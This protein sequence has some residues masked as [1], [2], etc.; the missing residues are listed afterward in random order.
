MSN[1]PEQM[2]PPQSAKLLVNVD[3]VTYKGESA[4]NIAPPVDGWL[5]AEAASLLLNAHEL[6]LTLNGK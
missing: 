5:M 3:P 2:A 6:T 4:V 1:R